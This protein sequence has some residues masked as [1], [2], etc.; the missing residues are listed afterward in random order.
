[1]FKEL[2]M[3]N[4]RSYNSLYPKNNS[5]DNTLLGQGGGGGNFYQGPDPEP[6][7]DFDESEEDE[8]DREETAVYPPFDPNSIKVVTVEEITDD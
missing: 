3:L 5:V 4:T 2:T 6:K 7:D 1:M 8:T